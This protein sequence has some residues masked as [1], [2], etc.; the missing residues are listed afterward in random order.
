MLSAVLRSHQIPTV[1]FR[2]T[3]LFGLPLPSPAPAESMGVL[4]LG[5]RSLSRSNRIFWHPISARRTEDAQ[6]KALARAGLEDSSLDGLGI[7]FAAASCCRA[8][9]VSLRLSLSGFAFSCSMVQCI[10]KW[11]S[12]TLSPPEITPC[13]WFLTVIA[14]S[15]F[16]PP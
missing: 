15:P 14:L 7:C 13:F 5:N 9:A 16:Q 12:S 8:P 10:H 3:S 2:F 11:A 4:F 6:C 1:N